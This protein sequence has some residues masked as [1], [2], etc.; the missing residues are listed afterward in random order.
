MFGARC[1]ALRGVQLGEYVLQRE[2]AVEGGRS[3]GAVDI[4]GTTQGQSR[5]IAR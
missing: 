3:D 5:E 1:E 2:S 4:Y